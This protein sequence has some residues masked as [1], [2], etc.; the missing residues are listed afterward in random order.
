MT[1]LAKTVVLRDEGCAK[2]LWSILR[3]NWQTMADAGKPLAVT[4]TEHKAKRSTEQNKRYWAIL[5]E[6][7]ECAWVDGKQFSQ[8][9]WHEFFR[10]KFIGLEDSPSGRQV[11]ISTA[12]LSV[13]EFADYMTK[14]D[15]Y[16]SS[17][18][19]VIVGV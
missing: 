7:A 2:F 6:V 12:K 15:A 14:V 8:E 10:G 11:G 19:G 18:L 16:V 4:V 5:R 3:N 1:A 13:S 17:E 9:A